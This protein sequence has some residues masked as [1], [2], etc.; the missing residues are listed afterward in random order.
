MG[1]LTDP[2]SQRNPLSYSMFH[3]HYVL[4]PLPGVTPPRS[5]PSSTLS[6]ASSKPAQCAPESR[7]QNNPLW[8][9][10]SHPSVPYRPWSHIAEDSPVFGALSLNYEQTLKPTL[11]NHENSPT[12]FFL[13]CVFSYRGLVESLTLSRAVEK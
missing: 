7:D 12:G 5:G 1:L 3:P 6:E 13:M 4:T 2:P 8:G 11:R 10:S 9:S